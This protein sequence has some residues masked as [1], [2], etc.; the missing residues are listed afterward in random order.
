MYV[1][2]DF[3]L[4]KMTKKKF[5]VYT[6]FYFFIIEKAKIQDSI[7]TLV[8]VLTKVAKIL[9]IPVLYFKK[10][11]NKNAFNTLVLVYTITLRK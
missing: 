1:N 4:S 5:F 8:P 9:L 2:S 6:D 7:Y 10:G 3:L 11:R